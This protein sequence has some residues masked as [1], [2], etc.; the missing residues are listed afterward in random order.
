MVP[1]DGTRADR[2]IRHPAV[3]GAR[4]ALV[5][6]VIVAVGAQIPTFARELLAGP[7]RVTEQGRSDFAVFALIG[8]SVW[9]VIAFVV[10]SLW[11]MLRPD[12]SQW[13]IAGVSLLIGVVIPFGVIAFL[14]LT[15]QEQIRTYCEDVSADG[16]ACPIQLDR[17]EVQDGILMVP[18]CGGRDTGRGVVRASLRGDRQEPP[19]VVGQFDKPPS[20][21]MLGSMSCAHVGCSSWHRWLG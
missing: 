9:F 18:G 19:G 21:A 16:D 15:P 13:L 8:F 1:N 2:K 11:F 17:V 4:F 14:D 5:F 3:R 6:G 12:A 20:V 10:A 7:V